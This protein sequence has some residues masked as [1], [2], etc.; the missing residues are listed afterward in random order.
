MQTSV[1]RPRGWVSYMGSDSPGHPLR[2]ETIW[3]WAYIPTDNNLVL[4]KRLYPKDDPCRPSWD[5]IKGDLAVS[6]HALETLDKMEAPVLLAMLAK[7]KNAGAG[8]GT[9]T[10]EA[11]TNKARTERMEPTCARLCADLHEEAGELDVSAPPLDDPAPQQYAWIEATAALLADAY[12]QRLD[13]AQRFRE[14]L[15][16]VKHASRSQELSPDD[17][18]EHQRM[19]KGLFEVLLLADSAVSAAERWRSDL[20]DRA[21]V[22][23]PDVAR[24]IQVVCAGIGHFDAS[25]MGDAVAE[26]RRI[27]VAAAEKRAAAGQKKWNLAA[28][29][30]TAEERAVFR[31]PATS[32]SVTREEKAI[33]NEADRC[34][35]SPDDAADLLQKC[36]RR[37]CL[38]YALKGDDSQK[39]GQLAHLDHKRS[40][41]DPGNFVWLCFEHHNSYD[42]RMGQAKNITE[43]ELRRHRQALYQAVEQGAVPAKH[44]ATVLKFSIERAAPMSITGDG[45]VIAGGDVNYVV[46]M[47]KNRRGKRPAASSPIIPGTVSEDAQMIG[48][49]RYLVDR[50]QKFKKWECDRTGQEMKYPVIHRAY[51]AKIKYELK[52]TP[53]S[54]FDGA[55]SFLQQRIR[56]TRLGRMKRNQRLYSDFQDFDGQTVEDEPLPV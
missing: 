14:Q 8:E 47:P 38:C 52:H 26:W 17:K 39:D 28:G 10:A 56:D 43:Q 20:W 22:F 12:G 45:N 25:R 51:K 11:G 40:N 42:S 53:R 55:V 9:A 31:V 35:L 30:W 54:L 50:Y 46:N 34:S 36:L 29:T 5:T 24:D 32:A 6:G 1:R 19:A 15:I 7:A 23:L 37:C 13:R 16:N 27:E 44:G 18:R 21:K 4:L 41:G 33:V 48:Y 3:R 49:L 2:V